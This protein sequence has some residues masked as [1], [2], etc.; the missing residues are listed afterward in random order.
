M[1]A[2]LKASGFR[3]AILESGALRMSLQGISDFV[4]ASKPKIVGITSPTILA[5]S[6]SQLASRIKDIDRNIRIV[7]GGAHVTALPEETLTRCSS[8]DFG[9]IGEGEN[10]IVELARYLIH[11]EGDIEKIRGLVYRK[12]GRIYC[13]ESRPLI[14]DI[15]T[16]AIPAWELIPNFPAAYRP[17]AY[18]YCLLPSANLISSRG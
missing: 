5:A 8:I 4:K 14:E 1:A 17:A 13:S 16:L 15:D 11:S 2:K 6:A 18:S 9:V 10:T 7:I 12:G 3:P